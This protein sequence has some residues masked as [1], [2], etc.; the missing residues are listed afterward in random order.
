[1]SFYARNLASLE[2][3]HPVVKDAVCSGYPSGRLE[4]LNARNGEETVRATV[5][6]Y[7]RGKKLF[8]HSSFDPGMEGSRFATEQ[9]RE[10]KRINFLYGF[11]LGYHVQNMAKLL[12]P[13]C[14][15]MVFDM[16]LDIFREALKLRDLTELLDNHNVELFISNDLNYMTDNM[17]RVLGSGTD[18][19]VMFHGPSLTATEQ[20]YDELKFLLQEINLRKSIS[21]EYRDLMHFNY[22]KN[23]Q[24]IKR[25]VGEFFNRFKNVP[26]IIVSAGPSLDKN[27]HLLRGL[28]TKALIICVAHALK[29]LVKTNVNPHFIITIDPQ[30]ITLKQIEGL[31]HLDIPFIL[32]ATAEPK[33][34]ELYLGPKFIA[35]QHPGYLNPGEDDYLI[36]TGGSV[37]TAAL[38]IAIRMGGNP[39][40]Y[41]GQD[42]GFTHDK[43]HC[44]DSFHE[45]VAI[46]PLDTMRKV[47]GWNNTE[48]STTLGMLSFKRWIQSRIRNEHNITFINSTEGGALIEGFQHMP[49]CDAKARYLTQDHNIDEIIN[50]VMV[51]L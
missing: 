15:L 50:L 47:P 19:H 24:M 28:A 16:N 30:P 1:M 8:I 43:H 51:N 45:S 11:G 3:Y 23:R 35:C 7:G 13:G 33:N 31:E 34:A 6:E 9:M 42:L 38:D 21:Q 14:R 27:K 39:I 29:A 12:E 46:K 40:V 22:L 36:K 44:E 25:N 10:Q 32:M 17:A 49:F 37:S 20:Q 26:I 4:V 41:I 18:L 5:I 2:K 48:V